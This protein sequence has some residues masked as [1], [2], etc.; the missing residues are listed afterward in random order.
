MKLN[1]KQLYTYGGHD[2]SGLENYTLEGEKCWYRLYKADKLEKI[3]LSRMNFYGAMTADVVSITPGPEYDIPYYIMDW[4]ESED[5]I[6]FICDLMPSD[7]LGRNLEHLQ[8]YYYE[9]LE[10]MY[11][12]FSSVPGMK[13]SVFHWVRAIHSPYL[14]TGTV[15]KSHPDH[16]RA[17]YR[18]A[19]EYM[20]IWLKM[21]HEAKP[22]DPQS[23]YMKYINERRLKMRALYTEYDPGVGSLNKFLGDDLA[24]IAL[25]I[26]EP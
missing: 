13:P 7:D 19:I 16:V 8:K 6:F 9:Q 20:K 17:I 25:S 5:H 18:C 14:V 11:E 3:G 4:D 2:I 1:P 10:D 22:L 26:I 23:D 15:E 24:E 12:E 21:Y